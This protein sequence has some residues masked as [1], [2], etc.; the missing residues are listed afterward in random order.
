MRARRC[1]SGVKDFPRN[2]PFAENARCITMN[3]TRIWGDNPI[4]TR[5][6]E[7]HTR[8]VFPSPL[9]RSLFTSGRDA[10][11]VGKRWSFLSSQY[12]YSRPYLLIPTICSRPPQI[13][14]SKNQRRRHFDLPTAWENGLHK[15]GDKETLFVPWFRTP[16]RKARTQFISPVFY[17]AAELRLI[18]F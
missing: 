15:G 5:G 18:L 14:P 11:P 17:V 2:C 8:V 4:F 3:Q 16:T 9:H 1:E 13:S 10:W 7:S 6:P 12:P